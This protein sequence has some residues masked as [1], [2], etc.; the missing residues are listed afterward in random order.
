M[1]IMH[2]CVPALASG[3][4]SELRH[5]KLALRG[6]GFFVCAGV[7]SFHD[8]GPNLDCNV[9]QRAYEASMRF[10]ASEATRWIQSKPTTKPQ[11][12]WF[13]MSEGR[14]TPPD[15]EHPGVADAIRALDSR[16]ASVAQILAASIDQAL[17]LPY[18]G[19][20]QSSSRAM[21]RGLRYD[22]ATADGMGIGSHVDFGSFTLCHSNCDGLEALDKRGPEHQ[23]HRL[24]GGK[25]YFL[26]GSGLEK[27]SRREVR[28]VT[29]R[30]RLSTPCE[31]FSFC[32][33]HGV[34]TRQSGT[35]VVFPAVAAETA[36]AAAVAAAVSA[37]DSG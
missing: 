34:S 9:L 36:A 11:R 27:K 26:V 13:T 14:P 30:V 10:H 5:L 22:G 3:C 15:S 6:P 12:W 8:D 17:Q 28:A 32:R 16:L 18:N 7:D 4:A 29:H 37:M 25:L 33:L 19:F 20:L 2:V 31:R 23:W 24:A 21:L 35:R 1:T